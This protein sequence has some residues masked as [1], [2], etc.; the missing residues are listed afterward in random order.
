VT[1]WE[2]PDQPRQ[3]VGDGP[4]KAASQRFLNGGFG[5]AGQFGVWTPHH[6]NHLLVR[7][8]CGEMMDLNEDSETCV[9]GQPAPPEPA[10]W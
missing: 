1:A 8:S 6:G 9:C 5:L 3:L 10:Q 2:R 4:H 7:C